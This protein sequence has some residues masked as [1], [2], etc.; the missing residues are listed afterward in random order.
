[1]PLARI[2]IPVGRSAE[3][4]SAVGDVVYN[5]MLA[6]LSVPKNDRFQVITEHPAGGWSSIP[7][8]WASSAPRAQS[9][10]R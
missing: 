7:R 3:F 1:M 10:S 6:A 4:R 2:E 5:A 9:S 8:T